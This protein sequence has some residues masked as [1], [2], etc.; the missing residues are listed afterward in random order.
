MVDGKMLAKNI[1]KSLKKQVA[2]LDVA[3]VVFLIA[4]DPP[5]QTQV[6]MNMK[7]RLAAKIGITLVQ[8]IFSKKDTLADIQSIL[9]EEIGGH[10]NVFVS[11]I[12]QL[13]IPHEYSMGQ[14]MNMVDGIGDPD[15]LLQKTRNE[16]LDGAY[17]D[18]FA[19]PVALA[20]RVVLEY[21]GLWGA[22]PRLG[23]NIVVVGRGLLVG[24]AVSEMFENAHIDHMVI[25]LQTPKEERLRLLGE[26]DIIVSGTGD[27]W[28]ITAGTVKK[29][30]VVI[31]AGTMSV[32]GE[33]RGD[34]HPDV[35]QK[36]SVYTPVPG[37]IGPLS[38]ACL[39]QNI[40]EISS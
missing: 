24:Q 11:M 12:V 38:L 6:Y 3:P 28:H 1:R 35:Y 18:M 9:R 21:I 36:A 34:V 40:V 4:I 15:V 5:K 23:A 22:L 16:W 31:D 37:C 8:K 2:K 29:D 39:M 17:G 32:S 27:A 25:D 30:V 10:P 20:T 26:A 19:P 14:I 33:L 13:P 7:Q